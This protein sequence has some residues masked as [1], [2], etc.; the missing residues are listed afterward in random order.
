MSATNIDYA[1]TYFEFPE[2]TKIHGA[3]NYPTL[4]II[5]DEMKANAHSVASDLGGAAHGHYGLVVDPREYAMVPGTIPYVRPVHPG[6]LI[7]PPGT[8]QILATGLRADHKEDVRLFRE[9]NDVEQRIIKQIVQAIDPTYLKTLRDPNTNTI[10]CNIPRIFAYLFTNYGLIED[11]HLTEAEAKL[12]SFQYDLLDP[13]VKI[14]DEVE[15]LQHLGNAAV[16]PYSE[17]Q[18]IKFA[19]QI[20]KNTNDFETGIRTWIDLPRVDKTWVNFKTHFESAHRSLREVRGNTMRSSS[21][22]QVNMILA[23][24]NNVRE[25]VLSAIALAVPEQQNEDVP[26]SHTEMVNQVSTREQASWDMIAA[27]K[28]LQKEIKDLKS[29]KNKSNTA[30]GHS[31]GYTTRHNKSKYCYT[32]GACAHEGKFCKKKRQGHKDDASFDDKMGGSTAYCQAVE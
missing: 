5:K 10:T 32:H 13:L 8:T 27:I 12:R 14:F 24:V 11:S 15:E 3:P 2:L 30:Q 17:A 26:S 23:E 22:N 25:S 28:D 31:R 16:D 29:S 6:P 9:A 1:N 19:L 18:L 7:I 4:R 21:F 20:I